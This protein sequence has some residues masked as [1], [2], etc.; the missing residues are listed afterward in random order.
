MKRDFRFVS[1][2]Q[3]DT[4]NVTIRY[5]CVQK[6]HRPLRS[7]PGA[8]CET[9]GPSSRLL[10]DLGL[11]LSV[12]NLSLLLVL[13]TPG[14]SLVNTEQSSDIYIEINPLQSL[15]LS[16]AW[17]EDLPSAGK[18]SACSVWGRRRI[19]GRSCSRQHR[20]RPARP[21]V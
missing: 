12:L 17:Q 19:S 8:S 3:F 11:L 13:L 9:P 10:P 16:L 6:V 2:F 15:T 7:D 4:Q 18:V 20:P 1:L 14:V 21:A 5:S